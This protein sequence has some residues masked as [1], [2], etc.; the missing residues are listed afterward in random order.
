MN[1]GAQLS[2]QTYQATTVNKNELNLEKENI[3]TSLR[4]GLITME[5]ASKLLRE[6]CSRGMYK[7]NSWLLPD[8]P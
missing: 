2:Y 1:V 7:T 5:Q 4:T 3:F 6:L 8:D